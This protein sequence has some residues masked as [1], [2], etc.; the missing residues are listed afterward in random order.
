M[1]KYHVKEV[2][3]VEV[4]SPIVLKYGINYATYHIDEVF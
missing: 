4:K 2:K 3:I 1:K